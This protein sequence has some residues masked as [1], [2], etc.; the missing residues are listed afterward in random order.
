MNVCHVCAEAQGCQKKASDF[1]ELEFEG[2]VS[3]AVWVRA[4]SL[5]R[6]YRNREIKAILLLII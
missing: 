5:T 2:V 1:L 3:C 6:L 4:K